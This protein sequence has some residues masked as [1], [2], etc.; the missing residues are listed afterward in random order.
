MKRI[1]CLLLCLCLCLSS[2]V[3]MAQEESAYQTKWDLTQ[4]Y[5]DQAAFDAAYA[6]LEA[7]L[8]EFEAFRGAIATPEGMLGYLRLFNELNPVL[9]RLYCYANFQNT[10]DVTDAGAKALLARAIA[11]DSRLN[12]AKSFVD[13]EIAILSAQERAALAAAP[14]VKDYAH[15]LEYLTDEKKVYLSEETNQT[16]AALN[17][18]LYTADTVYSTLLYGDLPYPTYVLPDGSEVT[19]NAATYTTLVY[20]HTPRENLIEMSALRAMRIK[21]YENT[22]AACLDA[23][24][25]TTWDMAQ[26]NRFGSTLEYELHKM[27]VDPAVYDMLV[28]AT[29]RGLSD[30]QRYYQIMKRALGLE[31]KDMYG[32][33]S[34]LPATEYQPEKTFAQSADDVLNALSIFGSE[35]TDTVR[36]ILETGHVD[37]YPGENKDTGAYSA[38]VDGQLLPYI[39]M[40]YITADNATTLAHELGH[41]LYS[42]LSARYQPVQYASPNIFTHEVASTTNEIIYYRT[43]YDRA[44]SDDERLYYLQKQ[45]DLFVGTFFTQVLFAEFEDYCYK[46]V[47]NG[48]TLSAAAL[49][50]EYRRLDDQ[51]YGDTFVRLE[52]A[53]ANWGGIPHFYYDYYVYQYA[54]SVCYASAVANRIYDGVEG[55]KESYLAFLKLGA[56]V[57][58]VDALTAAGVD[59]L[60]ESTYNDGLNYFKGLLDRYEELLGK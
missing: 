24:V 45:I 33:D 49:N 29:H 41:A 57:S 60:D 12:Q 52:G 5:A 32:F 10:L 39:T 31:G 53:E 47:E 35:Y 20:D 22:F 9:N 13:S 2:V 38:E 6:A 59:P 23:H 4:L 28:E 18:A 25:R 51:Y 19:L 58:P 36:E 26:I 44:Q 16:L 14:E 7:R 50:A 37:A 55:A 34:Y 42:Y 1:L 54:T 27:D 3:A 46:I 30:H 8:P 17:D 15:A 56:S 48:G 40:N 43:M 21:P 11:L